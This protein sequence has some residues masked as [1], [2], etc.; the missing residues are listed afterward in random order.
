MPRE[1]ERKKVSPRFFPRLFFA[2][3]LLSERLEQATSPLTNHLKDILWFN[4]NIVFCDYEIRGSARV[5]RPRS[6][7]YE[8]QPKKLTHYIVSRAK[9]RIYSNKRPTSN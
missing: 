9:Y 2:H 8:V 1:N 7:A 6:S 3:A 5:S 4:V